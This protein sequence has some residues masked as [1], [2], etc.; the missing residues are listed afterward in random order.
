M[1][2]THRLLTLHEKAFSWVLCGGR[3]QT[4]DVGR[5]QGKVIQT[6]EVTVVS[7]GQS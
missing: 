5:G 2:L 6:R 7:F 1:P 3:I 4:F